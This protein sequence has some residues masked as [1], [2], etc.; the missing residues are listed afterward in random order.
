MT[1]SGGDPVRRGPSVN[2]ER[3][4]V[5]DRPVKPGDDSGV[6][7]MTMECYPPNF[8]ISASDTSKLA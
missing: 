1:G 7:A 5:L 4:G 6:R 8:A 2:H 3:L